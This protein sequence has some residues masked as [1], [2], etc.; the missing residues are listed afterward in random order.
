MFFYIVPLKLSINYYKVSQMNKQWKTK[1]IK[2]S[3]KEQIREQK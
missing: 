1:R 2:I 3:D